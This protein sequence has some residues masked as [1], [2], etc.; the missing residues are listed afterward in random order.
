MPQLFEEEF[1]VNFRIKSCTAEFPY[2]CYSVIE[3]ASQ[4]S[5]RAAGC[6]HRARGVGYPLELVRVPEIET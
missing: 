6:L 3:L 1:Q 2:C 4:N 5:E